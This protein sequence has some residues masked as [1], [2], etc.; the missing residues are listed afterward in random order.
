MVRAT[1]KK[2]NHNK[3]QIINKDM[4]NVEEAVKITTFLMPII[5]SIS[6]LIIM[7]AQYSSSNQNYATITG[8]WEAFFNNPLFIG[9]IIAITLSWLFLMSYYLTDRMHKRWLLVSGFLFVVAL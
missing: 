6:L 3:H 9:T 1:K 8:F 4:R 5:L 2:V 7:T